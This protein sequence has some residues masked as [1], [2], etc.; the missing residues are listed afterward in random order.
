MSNYLK[1]MYVHSV[2]KP[3][4]LCL[5]QEKWKKKKKTPHGEQILQVA[6]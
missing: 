4:T 1:Y 5:T 2:S 3:L 6:Q